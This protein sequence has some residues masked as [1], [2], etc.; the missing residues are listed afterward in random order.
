MPTTFWAR[1][2]NNTANNP[3]LN[4]T[5]DAAT[6]INFVPSGAS[7]DVL[8]DYNM[9]SVDPDTLVEINGIEYQFSFQ[10]SANLPTQKNDGAQQ[11]PDQFE[12]SQV[13]LIEVVDY[14]SAGDFNRFFFLPDE[15][16]TQAE[17]D[18]F[19]TGA[20]SLQ[21][22]DTTTTGVV[23]YVEGTMILTPDGERLIESLRPGDTVLTADN[24]PQPILWISHSMLSWPD[25]PECEKPIELQPGSLGYRLPSQRLCVSPQH[26]ILVRDPRKKVDVFVPAKGLADLT[27]VRVMMGK[28]QVVYYHLLLQNHEVLSANGV[29]SESF[30]PGK[31]ALKMLSLTQRSDLSKFLKSGYGPLARTSLSVRDTKT[32]A[33][34]FMQ[35]GNV[36]KSECK[37][38]AA[39]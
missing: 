10:L 8:L 1:T 26:R 37:T 36:M 29:P 21:S 7:G 3:A 35:K 11:V 13:F 39:A 2:D 24:G 20:I 17:M 30:Y 14:P 32:L 6:Q 22:I 9:G 25:A 28:K 16:A 12:G 19:G 15:D 23:C 34:E 18:D 31:Q 5:G 33:K 4:P 27:G 38:L